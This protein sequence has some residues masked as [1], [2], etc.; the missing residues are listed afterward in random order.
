MWRCLSNVIETGLGH[1]DEPKGITRYVK[2][3]LFFAFI[4]YMLGNCSNQLQIIYRVL[5]NYLFKIGFQGA[6]GKVWSA[7]LDLPEV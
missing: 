5:T 6:F 4:V 2:Y 3:L 1:F 7:I